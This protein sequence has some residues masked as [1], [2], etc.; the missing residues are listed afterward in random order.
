MRLLRHRRRLSWRRSLPG[1]GSRPT[2]RMSMPFSLVLLVVPC[3]LV[4]CIPMGDKPPP[5][6]APVVAVTFPA[7]APAAPAAASTSAPPAAPVERTA[8]APGAQAT[9]RA[10]ALHLVAFDEF[11]PALLDRLA[12][13]FRDKYGIA[14]TVLPAVSVAPDA[15]DLRRQQVIGE[16]LIEAIAA[17][18][19]AGE[20]GSVV[21]GLTEYDMM[22]QD[23]PQWRFAFSDRDESRGLAVISTARMDPRSFGLPDDQDLLFH[24]VAKMVAKSVGIL[25]LGL[26]PSADP[27]SVMYNNILS[28][29]DLDRMGEDLYPR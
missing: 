21:I 27:G 11:P 19:P 16:R 6:T 10:R 2:A 12:A 18:A 22:L 8:A 1:T 13:Y 29:Q 4:S 24:R 26:P 28:L 5:G 20:P 17:A 14:L 3:V 25:Y 23:M 7:Q 9:P 15:V